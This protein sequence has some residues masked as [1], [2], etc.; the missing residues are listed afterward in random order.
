MNNILN[1]GWF[2]SLLGFL[3]LIVGFI[4][5]ILYRS[6]RIGA[7]P[8]CQ[9]KTLRLI[10]KGDQELP[11]E[12]KILYNG[13]EVPRLSLTHA[14]FWNSGK[15]SIGGEQMVEDDPLRFTFDGSDEILKAHIATSSRDVNKFSVAVPPDSK[16][17]ARV[18][19]DF[20]DPNDGVRIDLL[21]TSPRR[22][23]RISGTF[24]GIPKGII[25]LT[26][27]AKPSFGLELSRIFRNKLVLG[28]LLGVGLLAILISLLPSESLL[29]VKD[30]LG[31]KTEKDPTRELVSLRIAIAIVGILYTLMPIMVFLNLRTKY[32]SSL[33]VQETQ[34]SAELF[35]ESRMSAYDEAY[36]HFTNM[37]SY[38][39][40]R[41]NG[42]SSKLAPG[43]RKY[44]KLG[45]LE[46]MNEV[47]AAQMQLLSLCGKHVRSILS[48]AEPEWLNDVGSFGKI[49]P[50]I[51]QKLKE[52]AF[53][54]RP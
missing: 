43:E 10:S 32:P 37:L 42:Y 26:V 34:E 23:P 14:Y 17:M 45:V 11:E 53:K 19:F 5:I 25:D 46:S 29:V 44:T 24:R 33:D 50:L 9:M 15:A 48:E 36:K 51:E 39:I 8:T 3:G 27:S 4:G 47:K 13:D 40:G 2:G 16:N 21:H 41:Y 35:A 31:S 12:V 38:A 52:T 7:R 49:A 20:I 54:D 28:I 30:F 22:F 6:S 1:Q 18:G